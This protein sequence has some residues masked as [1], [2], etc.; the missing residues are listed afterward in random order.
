M[1]LFHQYKVVNRWQWLRYGIGV[2]IVLAG[3]SLWLGKLWH[4]LS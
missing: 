3:A 1:P 4:L 2:L